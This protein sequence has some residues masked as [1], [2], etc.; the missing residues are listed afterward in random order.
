ML[1]H[2]H[3][4]DRPNNTC[5][6][7]LVS[8]SPHYRR[9]SFINILL[10]SFG[11]NQC[12][13]QKS[14]DISVP[15]LNSRNLCYNNRFDVLSYH[16]STLFMLEDCSLHCC[17]GNGHTLVANWFYGALSSVESYTPWGEQD[18]NDLLQGFTSKNKQGQMTW[19]HELFC[20]K[21]LR[22]IPLKHGGYQ[23]E[24]TKTQF[25]KHIREHSRQDTDCIGVIGQ[26][27]VDTNGSKVKETTGNTVD[28]LNEGG[29]L[30]RNYDFFWLTNWESCFCFSSR[31]FSSIQLVHFLRSLIWCEVIVS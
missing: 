31:D 5:Q 14:V 6:Q 16:I 26:G 25:A 13:P 28:T 3:K 9:P 12:V 7:W 8:L 20:W 29:K 17:Y 11:S 19:L 2:Q 4:A 23:K 22:G 27:V 18:I 30:G 15:W 10:V 1:F 21:S 24:Q